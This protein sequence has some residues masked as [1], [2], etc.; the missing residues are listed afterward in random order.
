MLTTVSSHA[1]ALAGSA[2]H[3]LDAAM[4]T[5]ALLMLKAPRP[6]FVK[7]RLAAAIGAEEACDA[8][9]AMVERQISEIPTGWAKVA[10]F[11]PSDAGEEMMRWLGSGCQYRE[12]V[13]GDLGAR[14]DAAVCAARKAGFARAVLLGGDCPWLTREL[15]LQSE[16]E[17]ANYDLVI[18]PAM[19]GGYYL[20]GLNAGV[21]PPFAGIDW[22]TER[23]FAQTLNRAKESGARVCLLPKLED[24]DEVGAWNRARAAMI[25]SR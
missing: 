15:L 5:A 17:L 18:G 11:A 2:K 10:H 24:V 21:E 23:V 14:M 25:L 7:T 4:S 20:L 3:S 6:G 8:Y 13:D 12:Q 22:S 16:R 9:R 19:D 1:R